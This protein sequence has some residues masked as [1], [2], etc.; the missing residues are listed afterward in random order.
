MSANG[1]GWV[2]IHRKIFDTPGYHAEPFCRNMAWIDLLLL[3]NHTPNFFYCRGQRINVER[4]QVGYSVKQLAARWGWSTGKVSTYLKHLEHDKKCERRKGN[5][6]SLITIVN[7]EKYQGQ[8]EILN[9]NRVAERTQIESQINT[10]KNDKNDKNEKN[11]SEGDSL[12]KNKFLNGNTIVTGVLK[13]DTQL[14]ADQ[15]IELVEYSKALQKNFAAEK[16]KSLWKLFTLTNAGK[17]YS[18]G[19]SPLNHFKHWIKKQ[20]DSSQGPILNKNSIG[21]PVYRDINHLVGRDIE[22][23]RP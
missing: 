20:P 2:K 17:S 23:D 19:D 16:I 1:S 8:E 18:Q 3:T 6:T 21:H 5:I 14:T 9:A 13:T 10:N 4:G 7:Y 15:I 22:F 12:A 11:E